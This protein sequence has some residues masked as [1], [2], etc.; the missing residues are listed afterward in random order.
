DVAIKWMNSEDA[1]IF[2][3]IRFRE[4]IYLYLLKSLILNQPETFFEKYTKKNNYE[5]YINECEIIYIVKTNNNIPIA[6]FLKCVLKRY[7]KE[8]NQQVRFNT[9]MKCGKFTYTPVLEKFEF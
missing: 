9:C 5:I 2:V 8:Q 1:P 3:Y 7:L 4:H 6:T